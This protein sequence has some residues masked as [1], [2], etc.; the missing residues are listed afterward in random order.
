[1]ARKKPDPWPQDPIA[2]EM[3]EK[4]R[5][6]YLGQLF[7]PILHMVQDIPLKWLVPG[8][9]PLG[10]LVILAAD[11]KEGKTALATALALAVATGTPFAG[12]P[13][14]QSAVL[15]LAGEEGPH[16]RR[17]LLRQSPLTDPATPFYTSYQQIPIDTE[18]G[19][20]AIDHWLSETDARFLVVDPLHAAT[21]GRSLT[22]A[23]AARKSLMRLK[24]LCAE[25]EVTALV[26]HHAKL[27]ALGARE[28]RV[29]ESSQLAATASMQVLLSRREL[30]ARESAS[31]A[32]HPSPAKTSKASRAKSEHPAPAPRTARLVT[33][34]CKGRGEFANCNIQLVSRAPLDYLVLKTPAPSV[35]L[36]PRRSYVEQQVLE[37]LQAGSLRSD[38]I[39]DALQINPGTCRNALTNLRREGLVAVVWKR[40][41]IRR[42][43]LVP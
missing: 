39:I 3:E 1:M 10:Y 26:L 11:P 32:P 27:P 29:A 24:T 8:W 13:T 19:I 9:L 21:S 38:Q 31:V 2:R 40:G 16:E 36:P 6:R 28:K 37:L 25:R 14:N 20:A 33:L 41:A 17:L 5:D 7:Y 30:T 12:M 35:A 34:H 43:G 4:E 15:W 23:W 22:D 42:Y 18:E